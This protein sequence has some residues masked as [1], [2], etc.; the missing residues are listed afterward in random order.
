MLGELMTNMTAPVGWYRFCDQD[1]ETL[2]QDQWT[3][4]Q[5]Q[6]FLKKLFEI[7]KKKSISRRAYVYV[8]K[9][10]YI[11]KFKNLWSEFC[12]LIQ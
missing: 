7:N 5:L 3:T 11:G 4:I 10:I 6:F 9:Y 2:D 1:H 12:K 8:Y